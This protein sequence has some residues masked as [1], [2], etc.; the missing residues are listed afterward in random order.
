[1]N[2]FIEE[3]GS[4]YLQGFSEGHWPLYSQQ[5]LPF[6]HF[7]LLLLLFF[8]LVKTQVIIMKNLENTNKQSGEEKYTKSH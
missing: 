7:L 5:F 4:D 8:F 3:P 1:M 6:L 2:P